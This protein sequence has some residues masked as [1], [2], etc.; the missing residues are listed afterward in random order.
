VSDVTRSGLSIHFEVE[1]SGEPLVLLHGA[2]AS[3]ETW[4]ME[5]LVPEVASQFRLVLIDLRGHGRSDKPHDPVAYL[6]SEQVADVVAVLDEI[7][8]ASAH[9]CGFSLGA[10]VAVRLAAEHPA[11]VRSL[12]TIGLPPWNLGFDDVPRRPAEVDWAEDLEQ[13][14]MAGMI[15][16]ATAEGRMGWAAMF[17]DSDPLAMAALLREAD[18]EP[19]VSGFLI[20]DLAL[21]MTCLW[22]ERD[23]EPMAPLPP[24]ARVI[25]VPGADHVGPLHDPAGLATA[26]REQA[27]AASI[28]A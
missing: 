2:L 23:A 28:T 17:R 12:V 6:I 10:L 14:G 26:I 15:E 3:L 24:Q 1:G 16:S 21:P 19:A 18:L 8:I 7:G 9:V 13:H 22:G 11:R 25:I 5:G 20:G 27:S 4:R